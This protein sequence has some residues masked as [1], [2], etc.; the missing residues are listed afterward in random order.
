MTA[1]RG[2]PKQQKAEDYK[3]VGRSVKQPVEEGVE[4]EI[5]DGIGG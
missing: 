3:D 4:F 2:P 1:V 5:L